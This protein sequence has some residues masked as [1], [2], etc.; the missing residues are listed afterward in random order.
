[1]YGL[2]ASACYCAGLV[3]A[4][5]NWPVIKTFE[6]LFLASAPQRN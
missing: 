2:L 3:Q 5:R 6:E 4:C 1:M